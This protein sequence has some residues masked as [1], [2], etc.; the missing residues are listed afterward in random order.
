MDPHHSKYDKFPS[1][2]GVSID[3][4][5]GGSNRFPLMTG[6]LKPYYGRFTIYSI[7]IEEVPTKSLL[8]WARLITLHHGGS[9][10]FLHMMSSID[11]LT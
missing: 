5:H 9:N 8:R 3:P 11:S 4:Y 10:K 2:V 7:H 6:L 1:M